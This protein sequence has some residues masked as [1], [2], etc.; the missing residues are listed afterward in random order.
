MK[1]TPE[2]EWLVLSLPPGMKSKILTRVLTDGFNLKDLII[3]PSSI[4]SS[5]VRLLGE[6]PA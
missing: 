3:E 1:A 4:E 5:Y 6:E 2:G